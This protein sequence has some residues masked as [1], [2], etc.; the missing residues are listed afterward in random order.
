MIVLEGVMGGDDGFPV[1]IVR[2]NESGA[3]VLRATNEGGYADTEVNLEQLLSWLAKV[4]PGN[5]NPEAIMARLA[6]MDGQ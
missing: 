1:E 4:S 5:I 6:E 3:F 2:D